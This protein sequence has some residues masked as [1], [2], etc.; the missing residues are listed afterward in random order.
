M[1]VLKGIMAGKETKANNDYKQKS[2]KVFLPY[3]SFQI[4]GIRAPFVRFNQ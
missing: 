2:L 4:Q 1:K 3:G